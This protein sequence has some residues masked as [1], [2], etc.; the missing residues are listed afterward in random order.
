[1]QRKIHR[2]TSLK[3]ICPRPKSLQAE[4][5]LFLSFAFEQRQSWFLIFVEQVSHSPSGLFQMSLSQEMDSLPASVQALLIQF[6]K[7]YAM[8]FFFKSWALF[9]FLCYVKRKTVYM[10]EKKG[11]IGS[12]SLGMQCQFKFGQKIRVL[13]LAYFIARR[14][15]CKEEK[16]CYLRSG[17]LEMKGSRK[18]YWSTLLGVIHGRQWRGQD[19][20]EGERRWLAI[21]ISAIL[22]KDLEIGWPLTVVPNWGESLFVLTAVVRYLWATLGNSVTLYGA[23]PWS[24]DSDP[25]QGQSYKPSEA[26]ILNWKGDPSEAP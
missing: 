18:V 25:G 23:V 17:N 13:S 21:E 22:W 14:W 8:C 6:S 1:M 15:Y 16:E 5:L 26:D 20:A 2:W 7:V 12:K 19:W 9:R 4:S 10:I 11:L 24:W 3:I